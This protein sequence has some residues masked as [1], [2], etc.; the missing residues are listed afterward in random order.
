MHTMLV[1]A[2]MFGGHVGEGEMMQAAAKIHR[3]CFIIEW[4]A[5]VD[6]TGPKV[7][8]TL[9]IFLIILFKVLL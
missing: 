8:I 1:L 4:T 7:I 9:L 6:L 2:A 5:V 3:V